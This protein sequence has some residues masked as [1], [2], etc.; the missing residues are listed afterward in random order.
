MA[1]YTILQS[2]SD[3]HSTEKTLVANIDGEQVDTLD[4]FYEELIAQ[5]K[6]PD[7]FGRNFDAFD[8]M[9]ND[10]DWLDET[11]IKIVFKNYDDFLSEEN[12]ESREI[13]LTILDDAAAEWKRNDDTKKLKMYV[14]PS[15]L[16]ED[17]LETLGIEYQQG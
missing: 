7:N 13:L 4:K 12:D 14:E 3:R 6:F 10:L 8:E 9:I 1:N 5:L 17:D 15:E 2:L 11:T 16:A